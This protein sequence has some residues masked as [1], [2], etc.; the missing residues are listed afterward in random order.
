M[1]T[2]KE[3]NL[4]KGD[5]TTRTKALRHLAA[6]ASPKHWP[7]VVDD[8]LSLLDTI[9]QFVINPEKPGSIYPGLLK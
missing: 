1:K 2:K 6:T 9:D 7:E 3:N 4:K 5:R 8:I